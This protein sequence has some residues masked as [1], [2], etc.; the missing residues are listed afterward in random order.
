MTD[1]NSVNS[2]TTLTPPALGKPVKF[3]RKR[4]AATKC[5]RKPA[6]RT[7]FFHWIPF[8]F[9]GEPVEETKERPAPGSP[10]S[11]WI[12]YRK[13]KTDDEL[14]DDATQYKP[15]TSATRYVEEFTRQRETLSRWGPTQWPDYYTMEFESKFLVGVVKKRSRR[16]R[17]KHSWV[18]PFVIDT[19]VHYNWDSDI[20]T[21]EQGRNNITLCSNDLKI[22]L[23]DCDLLFEGLPAGEPGPPR[24]PAE[25]ERRRKHKAIREQW[26]P[27]IGRKNREP[28]EEFVEEFRRE[29]YEKTGPR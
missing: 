4:I 7:L 29:L 8:R 19:R 27:V 11:V 13:Q 17:G 5:I 14:I 21:L 10:R 24:D 9:A 18:M 22:L 2:D 25:R 12:E 26:P 6:R 1:D 16:S 3:K 28:T 15:Y 20:I 23:R